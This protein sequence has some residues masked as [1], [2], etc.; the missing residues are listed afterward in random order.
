MSPL[1][2]ACFSFEVVSGLDI[3][4]NVTIDMFKFRNPAVLYIFCDHTLP[5]L[6]HN[7]P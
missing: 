6:P 4:I 3:S 2:K 5:T 1:A 7:K